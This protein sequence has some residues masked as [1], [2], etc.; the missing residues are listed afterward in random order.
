MSDWDTYWAAADAKSIT[1]PPAIT[2]WRRL[3]NFL[4]G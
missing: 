4:K 2:L 3:I 1:T